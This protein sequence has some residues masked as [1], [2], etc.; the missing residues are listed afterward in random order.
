MTE[1]LVLSLRGR[2]SRAVLNK[3]IIRVTAKEQVSRDHKLEGSPEFGSL[4][5]YARTPTGKWI[6]QGYLFYVAPDSSLAGAVSSASTH[7]IFFSES[8]L[9]RNAAHVGPDC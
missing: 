7:H 1:A 3:H 5:G 9:L 2:K 4:V 6:R 8:L